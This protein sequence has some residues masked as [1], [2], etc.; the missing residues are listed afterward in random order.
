MSQIRFGGG[1]A[2]LIFT[3]GSMAIFL[4]G[5]PVLWYFFALALAL[6]IGFA[7]IFRFAYR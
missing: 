7:V 2:G 3:L 1:I 4:L 5:V 6:G